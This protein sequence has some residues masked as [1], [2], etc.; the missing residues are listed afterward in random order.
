MKG[1][2]NH[3]S[4]QLGLK[5]PA[6]KAFLSCT[7]ETAKDEGDSWFCGFGGIFTMNLSLFIVGPITLIDSQVYRVL[8]HS[9]L[10]L[11]A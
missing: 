8:T 10:L 7:L 4:D 11:R 9:I 1:L 3:P 6:K 2:E 5:L